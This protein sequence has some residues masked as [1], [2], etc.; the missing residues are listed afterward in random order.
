MKQSILLTVFLVVTFYGYSQ[1]VKM[2]DEARNNYVQGE[3]SEK[4]RAEEKKMVVYAILRAKSEAGS[5]FMEL[6][7]EE[8]SRELSTKASMMKFPELMKVT[9]LKLSSKSEVDLLN[10]LAENDWEIVAIENDSEKKEVLRK[11]YL[12]KMISL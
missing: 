4:E 6:N 8:G 3:T 9:R 10:Y 11:Y 7:L 5:D 2:S 1:K 12:R